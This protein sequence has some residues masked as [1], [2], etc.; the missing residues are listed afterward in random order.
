MQ[1]V[2]HQHPSVD[3]KPFV[4]LAENKGIHDDALVVGTR[5]HVYPID[6]GCGDE[7]QLLR[8][9]RC[10]HYSSHVCGCSQDFRVKDNDK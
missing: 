8:E 5:E 10:G 7:V 4:L 6:N 1:M 9:V 2:R 3:V